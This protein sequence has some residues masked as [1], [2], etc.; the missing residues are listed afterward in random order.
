[1]TANRTVVDGCLR[2]DCGRDDGDRHVVF[3]VTGYSGPIP[4]RATGS[5]AHSRVETGRSG[6]HADG[7][8]IGVGTVENGDKMLIAMVAPRTRH[9]ES[10]PTRAG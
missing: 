7:L 5:F 6:G 10:E 9:S 4:N 8:A 2:V 1:V 3:G